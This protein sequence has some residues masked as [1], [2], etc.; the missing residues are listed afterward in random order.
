MF[1]KPECPLMYNM[2]QCCTK[3]ILNT[4]WMTFIIFMRYFHLQKS[5]NLWTQKPEQQSKFN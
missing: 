3:I 2:N 1:N 4:P 5:M